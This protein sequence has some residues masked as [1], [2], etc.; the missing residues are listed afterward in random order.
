MQKMALSLEF[1]RMLTFDDFIMYS[2]YPTKIYMKNMGG[3]AR[4]SIVEKLAF[5]G[6]PWG[7]IFSMVEIFSNFVFFVMRTP[8]ELGIYSLQKF[9]H[10]F[11]RPSKA[12]GSPLGVSFF[13][14]YKFS[15]IVFFVMRTPYGLRIYS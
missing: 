13:R 4:N 1:F 6:S 8:Y 5:L 3:S 11:F 14:W 9:D 15:L 2:S 7:V 10:K 12:Q